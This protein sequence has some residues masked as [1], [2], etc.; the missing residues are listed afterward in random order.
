ME[1]RKINW[2][3]AFAQW[4]YTKALPADENGLTNPYHGVSY[5]EY[6]DKVLP[7]LISYEHPVN[8][9]DWFVPETYYYLWDEGCLVGEFRIRH[10]LTEALRNGAG[11]IGYSI[12][13]DLRGKGYGTQ[14]LR[15][16]L[17]IARGI[18]PEEEIYLRVNKDNI[19]SRKVMLKNGART[20]GEDEGHYFMR[21]P[22]QVHLSDKGRLEDIQKEETDPVKENYREEMKRCL[23][24]QRARYPLMAE[25]DT[26]KFAFQGMFGVGHLIRSEAD[27][28]TRLRDEMAGLEPDG[29]EP[30]IEKISPE[31]VRMN[32]RAAKA[33]GIGEEEIARLL[34]RSAEKEL[35]PF[36]RRDVYDFCMKTDG[37][38]K[39][40]VAAEKV[41]DENWVPSHSRQYR[42]AYHPAYRVLRREMAEH[43]RFK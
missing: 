35:L 3:D 27:A 8:M 40:R 26:V 28:A 19:A 32:L 7:A 42:E 14:G 36:T 2:Q 30:L 34:C 12:R 31:W 33:R 15:M 23:A 20:A 16:T 9:P 39:M 24:E 5:E 11:H 4:E 17:E 43:V 22:K 1:L 6:M 10:Y 21:I 41:L 38:E 29:E 25:E 13:K 18:V 37:S